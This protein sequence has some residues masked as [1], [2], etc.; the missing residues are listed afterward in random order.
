MIGAALGLASNAISG[1]IGLAQMN[2]ANK[3][4]QT[5]KNAQMAAM[6]EFKNIKEQNPYAYVTAP[7]KAYTTAFDRNQALMTN[8]LQATQGAGAEGVIGGVGNIAAANQASN[9]D[10]ASQQ[11]EAVYNRDVAQA[12]AQSGINQRQA[13]REED[14][15]GMK[16]GQAMQG[17]QTAE[18]NKQ[19]GFEGLEKGITGAMGGAAG[20]IGLYGKNRSGAGQSGSFSGTTVPTQQQNMMSQEYINSIKNTTPF[21]WVGAG[22]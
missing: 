9:L 14:I 15:A 3:Q 11:A 1:I 10:I 16:L 2:K 18:A 12:N 20:L 6:N 22:Q 21:G 17:Q 7:T 4:I 5:A 8:A 13:L 19:A